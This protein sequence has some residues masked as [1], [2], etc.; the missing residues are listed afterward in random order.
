MFRQTARGTRTTGTAVV[1]AAVVVDPPLEGP[2]VSMRGRVRALLVVG[3][4]AA[5]PG[6]LA[7]ATARAATSSTRRRTVASGETWEI[8]RITR[9]DELVVEDGA[10]LTVAEGCSLS[11]TVNGVETG[12]RLDGTY[13]FATVIAA[14]VYRGDVVLTPAVDHLESFAGAAFHLRQA[15]YVGADGVVSEN[16]V[17]SAVRGGRLTDDSA[18]NVTV[19]STGEAFNGF[20]VAGGA[21]Y[22]LASPKV[23]FDGNGRLDF[24]CDGAALTGSGAGTR[25]V[26]EDADVDNRGSVRTGVIAHDGADVIVKNSRIRTREGV[27]PDDYEPGFGANMMTVPWML[28]LS[29]NVRATNVLGANTTATYINSTVS[30]EEWGAMSTDSVRNSRLNAVNSTVAVTGA[31]G[32]GTYADGTSQRNV[33]LGTHFDVATFVAISTGSPVTFGDSTRRAVAA[34]DEDCDLRLTARELAAIEPRGCRLT[35]RGFGVMWHSGDGGSV[36]IG[37]DTRFTTEKTM[38]LDKGKQVAITVDGSR[39]ARL[40]TGN[41]VLVQIMETDDP[42]SMTG[43]YSDPTDAPERDSSF[44]TTTEHTADATAAFTDISL[45]GDFYNA[46]RTGKNLVVTFERSRIQGVLS[47]SRTRHALATIT[48]DDWQEINHVTNTVQPAVNN[49]VI[50]HLGAKS[51]WTVSGTS[52]LTKLVVAAD[53]QVKAPRGRSLAFSVDGVDTVLAPGAT[54]AGALE[55]TV[56][57]AQP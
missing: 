14:G 37:G 48:A 31:S 51:V 52:H 8:G 43:S 5:A 24:A 36:D 33:F 39:G 1:P 25:L 28:G 10:T 40:S 2:E 19:R 18:R 56:T 47:S 15:V 22:R 42:G 17:L 4:L 16:S 12:S 26:V 20:F 27:L 57:P 49:G 35:S 54:Y 23:R 7:P 11:L 9:L 30:S 46:M 38:F 34:L 45:T 21:S 32:Y 50:V 55:L 3:G 6:V 13:G 44:D 53:A 41:G 29:G